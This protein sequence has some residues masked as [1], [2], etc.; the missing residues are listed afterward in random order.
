MWNNIHHG[1]ELQLRRA[2]DPLDSLLSLS[3]SLSD[4]IVMANYGYFQ[5]KANP[6]VFVLCPAS[7]PS[8]FLYQLQSENSHEKQAIKKVRVSVTKYSGAF[9]R[10]DVKKTPGNKHLSLNDIQSDKLSAKDKARVLHQQQQ[11]APDTIHVFS[12]ASGHLYERF[13]KVMI[14]S[15]LK[16]TSHPV[17]FWFIE[18]FLSPNFKDMIPKLADHYGFQLELITYQWPSWL[19]EQ[20]EKQRTV[21]GYK[22]LFL[23]VLFPLNVNRIIFIDADL[24]VRSDL[25]ELMQMDLGGAPYG[26]TPFCNDRK[27]MEEYRFWE[28]GFWK[29]H[30][31]SKPYHISALYVIDL[32]KFRRMAAG[33]SLFSIYS[34]LTQDRNFLANLDQDLPNFLQ[35]SVPI[36]SLP[37]EWL[38]C[39]A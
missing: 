23:D 32:Q 15:I 33:D 17:K 1:L 7:G 14:M 37:Q 12:L 24:V 36:F 31:G 35:H 13:L 18:N 5:L 21:W 26:Y 27:E 4:T 3:L 20:T 28:R 6:G 19:F 8:S 9:V 16:T 39:D 30:L 29:A 34:Q 25:Q 2:S 38:Y 10:L 11:Y 22:I